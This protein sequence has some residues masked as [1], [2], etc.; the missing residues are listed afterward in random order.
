M[1]SCTLLGFIVIVMSKKFIKL[2]FF[3]YYSRELYSSTAVIPKL[4]GAHRSGARNTES[5]KRKNLWE[6]SKTELPTD[7]IVYMSYFLTLQNP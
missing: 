2:S 4:G 3:I 7:E 1:P 5:A 6:C